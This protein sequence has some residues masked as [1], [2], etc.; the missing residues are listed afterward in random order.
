MKNLLKRLFSFDS[1]P[2]SKPD[3][4]ATRVDAHAA[5]LVALAEATVAIR[6]WAGTKPAAAVADYADSLVIL[7]FLADSETTK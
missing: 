3:T 5:A 7:K 6:Q 1:A 2:A 4:Y